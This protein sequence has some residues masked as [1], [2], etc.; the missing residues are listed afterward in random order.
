[1][2]SLGVA[3][4]FFSIYLFLTRNRDVIKELPPVVETPEEVVTHPYQKTIDRISNLMIKEIEKSLSK[5]EF[6]ARITEWDDSF[7]KQMKR[8]I[9]NKIRDYF[10]KYEN[11]LDL[12]FSENSYILS[13][14]IVLIEKT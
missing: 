9:L 8:E 13:V 1:M 6:S 12:K 10:K 7:Q 3:F 5:G 11:D 2:I 4:V 14:K